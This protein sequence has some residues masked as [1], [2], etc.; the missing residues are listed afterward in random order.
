M[1]F[2]CGPLA[3]AAMVQGAHRNGLALNQKEY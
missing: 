2:L 1:R 3:N